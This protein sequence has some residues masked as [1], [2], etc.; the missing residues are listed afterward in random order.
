MHLDHAQADG[1]RC[2]NAASTN[3]AHSFVLEQVADKEGGQPAFVHVGTHEFVA[4]YDAPSSREGERK[5]KLC[6]CFCEHTCSSLMVSEVAS[7]A[8]KYPDYS[9]V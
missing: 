2:T 8:L 7:K 5:R 3:D 1:L 6:C 4:L 9:F